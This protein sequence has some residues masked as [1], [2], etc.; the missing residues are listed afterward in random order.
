MD[1]HS[2]VQKVPIMLRSQSFRKP[3]KYQTVISPDEKAEEIMN[4]KAASPDFLFSRS[5][6]ARAANGILDNSN[7][8]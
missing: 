2:D 1:C 4:L 6:L 3:V 8:K 7:P 5:K